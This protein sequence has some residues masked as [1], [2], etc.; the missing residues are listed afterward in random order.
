MTTFPVLQPR[1][2]TSWRHRLLAL[3]ALAGAVSAGIV[4]GSQEVTDFLREGPVRVT[5]LEGDRLQIV[6]G[7]GTLLGTGIA[8][9]AVWSGVQPL[10]LTVAALALVGGVFLIHALFMPALTL[11]GLALAVE[12]ASRVSRERLRQFGPRRYPVVWGIAGC[13]GR[14]WHRRFDLAVGLARSA[15]LR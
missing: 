1:S 10:R 4:L 2:A 5:S 3:A 13:G 12:G 14:R 8:V 11:V 9:G 6:L 7:L 15:A